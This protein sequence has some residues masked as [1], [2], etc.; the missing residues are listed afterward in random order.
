[1]LCREQAQSLPTTSEAVACLE[2][3]VLGDDAELG[4]EAFYADALEDL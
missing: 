1:V 4:L 3:G 2:N